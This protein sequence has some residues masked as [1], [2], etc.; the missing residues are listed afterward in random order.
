MV[1]LSR[2]E[3]TISRTPSLLEAGVPG[4]RPVNPELIRLAAREKRLVAALR[5][6]RA[7]MRAAGR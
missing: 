5:H 6:R 7:Q 4:A 2:V 3:A 1:E